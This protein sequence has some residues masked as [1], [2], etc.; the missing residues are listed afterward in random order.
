MATI[1]GANRTIMDAITPATVLDPGLAGGVV[2]CMIDSYTA[3][4]TETAGTLI[5]MG[6][7]LPTNSRVLDIIVYN[8][9]GSATMSVG[10]LESAARYEASVAAEATE[11]I[12]VAGGLGYKVDMTTAATPDNQIV[13]T[14]IGSTL[15]T[16]L[17][18]VV[19]IFYTID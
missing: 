18:S 13:L 3:D 10:D 1:K 8:A 5:E 6:G 17:T 19:V 4:G 14:T 9:D 16:S 7:E 2:R 15:T 12:S 11:H